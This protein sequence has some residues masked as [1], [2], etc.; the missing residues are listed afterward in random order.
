MVI[1][2]LRQFNAATLFPRMKPNE[3]GK[4]SIQT[5]A[6]PPPTMLWQVTGDKLATQLKMVSRVP[7]NWGCSPFQRHPPCH[8]PFP[9]PS[10]SPGTV[11]ARSA[12]G[13]VYVAISQ[14]PNPHSRPAVAFRRDHMNMGLDPVS[15]PSSG[16]STQVHVSLEAMLGGAR[17]VTSRPWNADQ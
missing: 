5:A 7:L 10:R 4:F 8:S 11:L 2:H 9:L 3:H 17:V 14:V 16:H 15:S 12:C 1:L 13:A 6:H